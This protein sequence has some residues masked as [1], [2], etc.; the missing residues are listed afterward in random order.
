MLCMAGLASQ[1]RRES[2]YARLVYGMIVHGVAAW[3][4][5]GP[6][7]KLYKLFVIELGYIQSSLV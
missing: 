4:V 7:A 5:P 3:H 1:T 6:K 2:G